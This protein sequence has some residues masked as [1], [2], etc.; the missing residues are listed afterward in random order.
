MQGIWPAQPNALLRWL[1]EAYF[2]PESKTAGE[3]FRAFCARRL[4]L[5]IV[6]DE[7]GRSSDPDIYAAGDVNTPLL[8]LHGAS[9][10]N[11]TTTI[12]IEVSSST[13]KPTSRL[14]PSPAIH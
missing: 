8:L 11:V 9:D 10:T 2:V 7:F 5:A 4:S 1:R 14:S 3:L 6:V 13:R 12:I